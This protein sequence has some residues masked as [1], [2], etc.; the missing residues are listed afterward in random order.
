[1]KKKWLDFE[2]TVIFV[3]QNYKFGLSYNWLK[4]NKRTVPNKKVLVGKIFEI[5]KRTA[6]VY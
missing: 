2:S 3:K 1:M 5:N 6:Y 4:S